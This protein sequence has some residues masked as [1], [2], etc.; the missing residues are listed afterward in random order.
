M[1]WIYFLFLGIKIS[2][3]A[4]PCPLALDRINEVLPPPKAFPPTMRIPKKETPKDI[5]KNPKGVLPVAVG[6]KDGH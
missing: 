1:S 2:L 6:K 5:S 3:T 4:F